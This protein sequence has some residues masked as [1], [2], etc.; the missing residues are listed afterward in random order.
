MKIKYFTYMEDG[1]VI[2]HKF[3][4]MAMF[5]ALIYGSYV[6]CW[7]GKFTRTIKDYRRTSVKKD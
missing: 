1:R 5:R 6:D 7:D 2:Y 4:F 3:L